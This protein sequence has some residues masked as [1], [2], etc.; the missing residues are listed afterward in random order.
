[1]L[2]VGLYIFVGNS[3]VISFG[4]IGFMCLGAYATAWFTIPPVM[5]SMTLPGLPACLAACAAA[6]LR[7]HRRSRG[8]FAALFAL[9]VGRDP[10]AACPA[11]PPRSPPSPCWRSINVVYSNWDSVTGGTGSIVGIPFTPA[12]GSAVGGAVSRD[13]RS[14]ISIRS[15][16][17]AWRLRA[18][19]RRGG[20]AQRPPASTSSASG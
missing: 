1:M 3:G 5:K 12:S 10:H 4:H 6:D 13:R 2:V 16:A 11:S 14:P 19:P 15:R 18:G 17:L 20:G 9:I 8:V 7:R